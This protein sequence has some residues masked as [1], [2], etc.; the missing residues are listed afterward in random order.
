MMHCSPIRFRVAA[1]AA[2]CLFLV[3]AVSFAKVER[4]DRAADFVAAKDDRNRRVKLKQYR[5]KIVVITFG[6]SWC[7]PCKKELVA[8]EKLARKY[9]ERGVVFLAVN[10]DKDVAKGKAFMK[11]A[12]LKAMRAVYEPGGTTV[13]SYDPPTMPTTYIVD[14]RGIVRHLH[15]G[16]RS[17]DEDKLAGQLDK[18]LK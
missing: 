3:P 4:G 11:K 7:K 14:Q 13:E 1:V 16:Y 5:G 12:K 6:A 9:K 8:W 10:I 15:A 17:G 18:L 2:L